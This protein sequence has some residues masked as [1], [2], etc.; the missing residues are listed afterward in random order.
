VEYV[1]IKYW[2]RRTVFVDGIESGM[3]DTVLTVGEEGYHH[4]E[5]SD[6]PNYYPIF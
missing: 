3:T 1:F 4:F 6:P 5:L 2:R